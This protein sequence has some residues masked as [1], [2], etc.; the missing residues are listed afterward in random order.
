MV[1]RRRQRGLYF[2]ADAAQLKSLVSTI[3]N[4]AGIRYVFTTRSK[5]PFIAKEDG[6]KYYDESYQFVPGKDEVIREGQ[7]G[8]V[9]CY[10]EML[11]RALDAVDRAREAG[12]DVGLINK[13]TLNV[14]DEDIVK[15]VGAAPF[16][17]V[18]GRRTKQRPRQ[19]LRDLARTRP[20]AEVRQQGVVRPSA[21]ASPNTS[22]IR[23]WT[24]TASR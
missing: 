4:D 5:V 8:Y 24:R 11:Y 7:A 19:P 2:A 1:S 23:A 3:W 9:V 21:A 17:L 12:I 13:P 22:P 6:S 14:I 20:G 10:G 18:V 15:K 16:A